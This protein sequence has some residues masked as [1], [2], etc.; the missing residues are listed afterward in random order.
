M[1]LTLIVWAA[2]LL[3]APPLFS[4]DVYSYVAQGAMARA[5]MDVYL[6]GPDLLGGPLLRDVAPAWR[7]TPAP[8][9]PVFLTV[10]DALEPTGVLGLRLLALAA[11]VLLAALLPPLARRCG[12]DPAAALWL[13]AL[14]P[15]VL[16]HLVA[17]AHNDAL[18]LALAAAALLAALDSRPVLAAVLVALAALVK[19]PAAL[20]LGVVASVWAAD[21]TGRLRTLRG[22][23]GALAVAAVTAAAVTAAA[24][25]GYGWVGALGTPVTSDNWSLTGL[26]GRLT[27]PLAGPEALPAWRAAGLAVTCCA[28]LAAW[29]HRARLGPVHALGLVLLAL[30]LLGPA[31]RPWYLLW[32]LVPLA[33]AAPP[34]RTRRCAAAA[35]CLFSLTVLPSGFPPDARQLALAVAG[36]GTAVLA[37]LA[38]RAS[39]GPRMASA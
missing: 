27:A 15:L 19:A 21:L 36:A 7:H 32:G 26:L 6:H 8:Y 31:L 4:R 18:M 5:G 39:R 33:A 34:G 9:G 30:A 37:L 10:A 17:G 16:L 12:V 23:L 11:V 14:N 13:G 20:G 38:L 25:T 29:R 28:A 3:A 24:G 2:P 35:S 1:T 22:L